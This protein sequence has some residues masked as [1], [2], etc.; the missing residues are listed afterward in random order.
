[1]NKI[2]NFF[3]E[4]CASFTGLII[5]FVV[6]ILFSYILN[7]YNITTNLLT[8]TLIVM[9]VSLLLILILVFRKRIKKD[10]IDFDNNYKKYLSIGLSSWAI[11]II[12]MAISNGLINMFVT[13]SIAY[14]QQVNQAIIS[15][16]PLYSIV[17]IIITGPFIEEIVFRLSFKTHLKNKYLYYFLTIFIFAGAHVFNGISSYSELLYFIPYGALAFSF[18]YTLDKTDNIFTTV[19]LHT[20]HNTIAVI[21]IAL[22]TFLG[23]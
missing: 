16:M 12:I 1:M 4:L 9:E 3:K 23:A 19:I 18:T 7:N 20:M 15:K 11:G 2:V 10:F 5:Y 13:N 22:M 14:N 8:I 6:N 21:L 17:A